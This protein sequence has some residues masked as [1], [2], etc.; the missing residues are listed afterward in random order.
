MF[1]D[2][3]ICFQIYLF[4][5]TTSKQRIMLIYRN[6]MQMFPVTDNAISDNELR[7]CK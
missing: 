7:F 5:Q 4:E 3:T 2:E 6:N 1:N